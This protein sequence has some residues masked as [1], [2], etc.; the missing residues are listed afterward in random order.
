MHVMFTED[1]ANHKAGNAD[2]VLNDQLDAIDL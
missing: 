2:M 1:S